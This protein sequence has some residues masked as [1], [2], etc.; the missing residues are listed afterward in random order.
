M[1]YTI[2][3]TEFQEKCLLNDIL[4]I[5]IWIQGAV[6]GKVANCKT[7]AADQEKALLIAENAESMPTSVD[8]L[9]ANLFARENY[10]NRVQRDATV[11]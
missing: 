4:D 1:Q 6:D 11:Q 2:E 8:V 9:A 5:Q 10:Q 3:L 7:R